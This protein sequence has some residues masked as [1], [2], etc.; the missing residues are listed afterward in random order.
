[1]RLSANEVQRLARHGRDTLERT[2]RPAVGVGGPSG[3][4]AGAGGVTGE[5]AVLR[6]ALTLNATMFVVEA[7]ADCGGEPLRG[8]GGG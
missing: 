8:G 1:M 2:Q 3:Q 4:P 7:V 6:I 5:R